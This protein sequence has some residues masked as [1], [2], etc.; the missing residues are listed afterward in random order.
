MNSLL[1]VVF[2]LTSLFHTALKSSIPAKGSTGASPAAVSLTF[3]ESINV[4][5]TTIAI[6]KADSSVVES[7]VVPTG[8]AAETVGAKVTK[9]LAAGKY[10]IKWKTASDDGH[11]VRGVIPFTVSAAVPH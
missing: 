4:K 6:T 9:A 7:L 1:T 8:P 5:L 3:T 2:A 11:V 10:L